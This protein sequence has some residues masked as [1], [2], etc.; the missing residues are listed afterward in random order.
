M[1]HWMQLVDKTCVGFLFF[2]F[3]QISF[4]GQYTKR[5]Y[6]VA[7]SNKLADTADKYMHTNWQAMASEL[8]GVSWSCEQ[9]LLNFPVLL[10]SLQHDSFLPTCFRSKFNFCKRDNK[11]CSNNFFGQKRN[12]W[13][14][15]NIEN[16]TPKHI[17]L[18]IISNFPSHELGCLKFHSN[19]PSHVWEVIS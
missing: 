7:G 19:F 1:G 6:L 17:M 8:P 4:W 15:F 2:L 18:M 16:V 14:C 10:L 5:E 3:Y 12:F 13:W 9:W 11:S